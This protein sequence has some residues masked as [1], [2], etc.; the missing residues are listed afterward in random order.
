MLLLRPF[1]LGLAPFMFVTDWDAFV[2][3]KDAPKKVGLHNSKYS[4]LYHVLWHS[5]SNTDTL[6][7]S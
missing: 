2:G 4:I 6:L 3:R 7:D 1:R 5:A